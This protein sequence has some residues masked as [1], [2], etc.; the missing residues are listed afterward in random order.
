MAK[1]LIIFLV[2]LAI[3]VPAFAITSAQDDE[4]VLYVALDVGPGGNNNAMPY[5]YGAGNTMFI[6]M[7]TPLFVWNADSTDVEPFI[8][9]S[10]ESNEDF[11]VWTFKLREDVYFS[12]GEQLTAA[13]VKFTADF[14]TAPDIALSRFSEVNLA[15][16]PI[17][18]FDEYR[19]G[20]ADELVGVQVQD[21]FTF[22]YTLS[23]PNPRMYGRMYH[24]YIFPEHAIDFEPSEYETTD[25][26]FSDKQV[27]AGPFHVSDFARDEFMELVPNEYYF[28]GEP[29][30]DR[31]VNRY[32]PD[33]TAAVLALTA[34]EIDFTYISPDVIGT[35]D[36]DTFEIWGGNS[37]VSVMFHLNYNTSPEPWQELKVRQAFLY[38]IDRDAIVETVLEGTHSV[39]PCTAPLT[40]VYPEGLNYFEYDPDKAKQLLDEAGVDP[41]DLGPIDWITH[42]GYT[43]PTHKD[44]IQAVQAYLAEIGIEAEMRYLDIATWRSTYLKEGY[45]MGYRGIAY[46]IF[47]PPIE[48]LYTNDGAHGGNVTGWDFE[49]TGFETVVEEILDAP[50]FEEYQAK[51]GELC[52]MENEQLPWLPMWV[53]DRFGAANQRIKDFYWYPAGGGGPYDDHAE[54]WY[55]ED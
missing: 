2:V 34:G 41:S 25:F 4:Q 3:T 23:E 31:L 50:T 47:G 46:R 52:M 54:L 12:D 55:I 6:K 38:A 8:V 21:D 32:F 35:L 29:K 27:G 39:L 19:N 10:Y 44:A 45:N 9:E 43:N 51:L 33:E 13:D 37:Y 20:E 36:E 30:L 22:T 18:G 28:K 24:T 48:L 53:G 16:G 11:T 17:L 42:P 5:N 7:F 15:F 49:A 40:D 1:K 14:M 26:W